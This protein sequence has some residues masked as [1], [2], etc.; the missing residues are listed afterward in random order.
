M[1]ASAGEHLHSQGARSAVQT[2]FSAEP[3]HEAPRCDST[4]GLE[5]GA[6]GHISS[7]VRSRRHAFKFPRVRTAQPVHTHTMTCTR[8]EQDAPDALEQQTLRMLAAIATRAQTARQR[9]LG[10]SLPEHPTRSCAKHGDTRAPDADPA[11]ADV[12]AAV[13]R[14]WKHRPRYGTATA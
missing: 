13:A 5:S 3:S 6:S 1:L 11:A 10:H 9:S 14:R 8:L 4:S 2:S 7:T 12:A